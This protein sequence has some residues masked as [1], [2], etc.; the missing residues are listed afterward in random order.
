MIV[1]S[2][3]CTLCMDNFCYHAS[4]LHSYH[5]Y[6]FSFHEIVL[7]C[8][9][10]FLP[11]LRIYRKIIAY[12]CFVFSPNCRCSWQCRPGSLPPCYVYLW[13]MMIYLYAHVH[14]VCISIPITYTR[15][16]FISFFY[17]YVGRTGI[18]IYVS[19]LGMIS[20]CNS[21]RIIESPWEGSFKGS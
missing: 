19:K 20:P 12:L 16:R 8:A 18:H 2:F 10:G 3:V 13:F 11:G 14:L 5:F 17:L 6:C 21:Y 1:I 15:D 9:D 7:E 4:H